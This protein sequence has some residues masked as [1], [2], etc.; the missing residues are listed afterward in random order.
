MC[1]LVG[2]AGCLLF[3][4]EFIVK[5]LLFFD[6][7][8]GPD[9]TGLA[10]VRTNGSV[11]LAKLCTNP[12]EFFQYE[13]FKKVLNGNASRA[14]IGHNRL[15]TRGDISSFNAHPFYIGN[16]VG[17]HNGTLEY[18]S[19]TALEQAINDGTK[20][21]V[22]SRA[23]F[24]GFAKLGVKETIGLC[25][26]G[27][28]SKEG[29]WALTWYDQEK[30]TINFLRNQHRELFYCFEEG[31][32]RMWWASE[33]WMLREAISASP[34]EV[35]LH[36]EKV[37]D[38]EN[39]AY[40][41]LPA[42]MWFEYKLE[43]LVKGAKKKPKAKV[44]PL[45]GKEPEPVVTYAM[46]YNNDPF[47]RADKERWFTPIGDQKEKTTSGIHGGAATNQNSTQK[48]GCSQTTHSHGRNDKKNI[49]HLPGS[50]LY[51]YA[52]IV[53]E[54]AFV[55]MGSKCWWCKAHVT[56]GTEGVTIL[57]REQMILCPNCC[58]ANSSLS[59][60]YINGQ[61]IDVLS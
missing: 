40:F 29:A 61:T 7:L 12:I 1:G 59:K 53:N 51:P 37:G 58:Q 54:E 47:G 56:F 43:D 35:K 3:Q 15:R 6:Y 10:A 13:P 32:K 4:D 39:V 46:G 5:R 48:T 52:N 8:R 19:V 57:D 36:T 2:A 17:A 25:Y 30:G 22:D 34:N 21:T 28:D 11:E 24:T 31:F 50:E 9:S 41:L 45:K 23:L 14:F 49:I 55:K 42:D 26:E 38:Q 44:T 60:I 18:K 27:K 33:P 16:I 20:F